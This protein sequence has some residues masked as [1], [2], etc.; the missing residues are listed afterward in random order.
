MNHYKF[1]NF[2]TRQIKEKSKGKNLLTVLNGRDVINAFKDKNI[3]ILAV[4]AYI[5]EI[6]PG[7]LSAAKKLN[8]VVCFQ[9]SLDEILTYENY[10][11]NCPATFLD[12]LTAYCDAEEYDLPFFLNIDNI[13]LNKDNVTEEGLKDLSSRI[14][15]FSEYGF[16]TFAINGSG[17]EIDDNILYSSKIANL[18]LEKNFGVE[19]TVESADQELPRLTDPSLCKYFISRLDAFKARPDLIEIYNGLKPGDAK[20]GEKILVDFN[21]TMKIAETVYPV[22]ISQHGVTG[23]PNSFLKQF[24]RSGIKKANVATLWKN[25][26]LAAFPK[27]MANEI[28]S[29]SQKNN[30]T[31]KEGFCFFSEEIKK[32]PLQNINLLNQMVE[33]V[34]LSFFKAFSA[35][36]SVAVLEKELNG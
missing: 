21:L 15:K 7:I 30:K 28:Q 24:P 11:K 36:N 34:A 3:T 18:I 32:L 22:A 13:E 23:T 8:A 19:I 25:I 14:E 33:E 27:K 4:N 31:I 26:A 17:F 1:R 9:L 10:Y 12:T 5:K 6:I 20:T 2:I 35:E 29:W 16:T